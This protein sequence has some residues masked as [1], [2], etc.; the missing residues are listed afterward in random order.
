MISTNLVALRRSLLKLVQRPQRGNHTDKVQQGLL[1]LAILICAPRRRPRATTMSQIARRSRPVP[2]RRPRMR[3]R[4]ARL[5][6]Q[7][8][9]QPRLRRTRTSRRR[10]TRAG[11]ATGLRTMATTHRRVGRGTGTSTGQRSRRKRLAVRGLQY[12]RVSNRDRVQQRTRLRNSPASAEKKTNG[13]NPL[14]TGRTMSEPNR[15]R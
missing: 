3:L 1:L 2:G 7:F 4:T 10:P 11:T 6:G 12:T 8:L 9:P 5:T 15:S 14:T 13:R